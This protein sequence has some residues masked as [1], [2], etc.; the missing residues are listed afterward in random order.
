[1]VL[2]SMHSIVGTKAIVTFFL[3]LF[4]FVSILDPSGSLFQLKALSFALSI[5]V[6][7]MFYMIDPGFSINRYLL[8]V[9]L[10]VVVIVPI[11]SYILLNVFSVDVHTA[12]ANQYLLS[13]LPLV[14]LLPIM[15]YGLQVEKMVVPPLIF[16]MSVVL[17]TSMVYWSGIP[18]YESVKFLLDDSMHAAKIGLRDFNGLLVLMVYYKTSILLVFLMAYYAKKE[19]FIHLCIVALAALAM[20]VTAA[21][22]N[23]IVA[24]I[25]LVVYAYFFLARKQN[26]LFSYAFV[27]MC[28]GV[29]IYLVYLIQEY[30]FSMTETSNT[31]KLG[32][33][34]GYIEYFSNGGLELLKGAGPGVGF[35]SPGYDRT[36]FVSELTYLELVRVYGLFSLPLFILIIYPCFKA[37]GIG[38]EY[39][40]AWIAFLLVAGSNPLLVSSTG[41][42]AILIIYGKIFSVGPD[43]RCK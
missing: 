36:I 19:R 26:K 43:G 25:L 39:F 35:Y 27:S 16:L 22:A 41:M 29:L 20:V 15:S 11:S 10:I 40:C 33:I 2:T 1:M 30:F 17:F 14:L 18:F 13:F 28:I 12:I 4:L 24:I 7:A 23:A 32:H 38:K 8:A 37:R 6:V 3:T 9:V 42:I 21:R 34:W 5:G 31:I